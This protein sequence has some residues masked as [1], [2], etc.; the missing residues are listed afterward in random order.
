MLFKDVQLLL[1]QSRAAHKN[2]DDFRQRSPEDQAHLQS[3]L[4]AAATG[5]F[6]VLESYLNG[7]AYDCFNSHHDQL[8]I[9]DHDLLGEWD[10][11]NNR[12]SYASFKTKLFCYPVVVARMQGRELDLSRCEFAN[13]LAG[14][15]KDVRNALTH[16]SYYID[17]EKGFQE[18][19]LFVTGVNLTLVE[20]IF[21]AAQEYVK[22]VE[23]AL[24]REAKQSVPWLFEK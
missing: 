21:A 7:L 16:P 23:S 22:L 24:G 17:P 1:A 14:Y 5:V 4:R 10:S 18:K 8:S 9:E 3:Y 13:D 19:L 12:I 20:Q 15:A 6:R 11:A 2:I